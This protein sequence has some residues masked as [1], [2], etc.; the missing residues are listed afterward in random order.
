MEKNILVFGASSSRK[1]I[2]HQ[3]AVWAASQLEDVTLDIVDLNDYEMPI[4]SVDKESTDGIPQLA[5]DFKNKINEADGIII[6]FAEHNGSVTAAFKNIFDWFSRIDK[7]IWA[8]K[9]MLLL[10]TSPGGRGAQSALQ[11]ATN[12]FP[13]QGG[14][15]TGTFSLPSFQQNFDSTQGIVNP[16]LATL[17][18]NNLA[19]FR[20]KVFK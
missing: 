10:S 20:S 5:I 3:L 17:L 15:V 14:L 13:H 6:S 19:S 12:S 4:F 11:I 2:N 18:A 7:P 16:E 1:S 8:N 9:P